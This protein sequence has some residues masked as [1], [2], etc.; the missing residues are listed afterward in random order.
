MKRFTSFPQNIMLLVVLGLFL[1][2]FS[3]V[4]VAF[5]GNLSYIS[6]S[7]KYIKKSESKL[8]KDVSKIVGTEKEEKDDKDEKNDKKSSGI[9]LFYS[10]QSLLC[11]LQKNVEYIDLLSQGKQTSDIF[12]LIHNLRL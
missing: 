9:K 10:A 1:F 5:D 6:L 7:A 8:L 11:V 2:A 12:I 4:V 3:N